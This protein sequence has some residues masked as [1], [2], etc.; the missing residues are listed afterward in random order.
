MEVFPKRIS[1]SSTAKNLRSRRGD[2]GRPMVKRRQS[3]R[4]AAT[5]KEDVAAERQLCQ[6]EA[7][8]TLCCY[9]ERMWNV[10]AERQLC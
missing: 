9:K 10:V 1:S 2:L 8:L 7:K 4:F 3:L 6:K 5:R